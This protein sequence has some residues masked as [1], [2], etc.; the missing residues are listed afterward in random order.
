MKFKK[1]A[2]AL[3]VAL[4]AGIFP[5][6][7]KNVGEKTQ[8]GYDDEATLSRPA[9]N[10]EDY[11]YLYNR[12]YKPLEQLRESLQFNLISGGD[13]LDAYEKRGAAAKEHPPR[14]CRKR[15]VTENSRRTENLR[16]STD[17]VSVCKTP[18]RR[19]FKSRL[20][21]VRRR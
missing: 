17:F 21:A 9:A 13:I 10:D 1:L 3:A 11:V 7:K 12:D 19:N 15:E 4:M 5:S 8:T 14:V 20:S 18:R 16:A 2:V 6:C